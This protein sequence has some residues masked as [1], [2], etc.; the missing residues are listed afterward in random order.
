[1]GLKEFLL[2]GVITG[3]LPPVWFVRRFTCEPFVLLRPRF[4]GLLP[5]LWGV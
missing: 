2:H 1:M 3:T 4:P 5:H